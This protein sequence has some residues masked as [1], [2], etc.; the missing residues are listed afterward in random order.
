MTAGAGSPDRL[1]LDEMFSPRIAEI[2][3]RHG[4]DCVCVADDPRLCAQDDE[5][6][7]SV[8]VEQGRVLVTNNVVDFERLRRARTSAGEPVPP[9]VYTDDA[10]FPRRRDFVGLLS[11]ALI[12]VARDRRVAAYGG[13]LWLSPPTA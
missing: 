4:I 10:S 1:L 12:V 3:A 11:D 9:L 7:L 2:L 8:A 6:V 5:T 13:V